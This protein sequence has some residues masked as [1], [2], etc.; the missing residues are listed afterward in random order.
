MEDSLDTGAV[1]NYLIA[2]GYDG[3]VR[4]TVSSAMTDDEAR[5]AMDQRGENCLWCKDRRNR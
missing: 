3:A 2:C 5:E 1:A 4:Q